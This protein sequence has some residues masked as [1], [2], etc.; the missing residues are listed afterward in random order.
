M[1]SHPAHRSPWTVA[2]RRCSSR[3]R[4]KRLELEPRVIDAHE[5]RRKAHRPEQKS[6]S[7]DAQVSRFP[8]AKHAASYGGLVPST[9]ESGGRDAHGH[10]A[11]RGSS[12][13]RAML[14]EAAHHARLRWHPLNPYFAASA[15]GAATRPR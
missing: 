10:I 13:L 12:E 6:D 3:A 9:F 8:S 11:K 1:A 15:R 4:L 14:C 5:V 2:L 7:R